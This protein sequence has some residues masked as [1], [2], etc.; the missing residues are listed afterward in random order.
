S[1][2]LLKASG[3]RYRVAGLEKLDPRGHYFFATNHESAFDIPLAFGGLPYH[4]VPIAK[5]ELRKIPIMGWAMVRAKHI[6]IDRQNYKKA[7]ESLREAGESLQ[8]HPRSVLIFPEGTRSTNGE[9]HRFKKGGL[10]LAVDLGM[11][12]VPMASCGTRDIVP[13]RS[14]VI[15]PG[16]IELKIGDPIDTKLWKEKG[17][18]EFSN[19]VRE[20]VILLRTSW[21]AGQ[22][23]ETEGEDA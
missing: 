14:F 16:K 4:V 3:V 21:A 6:F 17:R 7:M 23:A 10:G 1:L 13:K 22:K 11:P 9:I 18:T 19:F 15:H 8:R 2:I 20:Q 12:V 5:R